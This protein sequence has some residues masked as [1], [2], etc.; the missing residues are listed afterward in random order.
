MPSAKP[1]GVHTRRLLRPLSVIFLLAVATRAASF[2]ELSGTDFFEV[3]LGDARR[4]D[5]WAREIIAGDLLGREVFYQAPLY[6]YFLALVYKLAGPSAWAVRIVQAVAGALACVLLALAARR[7]FSHRVGVLAGVMLA[8]YPPAV[9]FDGLLQKASLGLLFSTGLILLLASLEE[10]SRRGWW[11]AVGTA[12]GA[13][14][15]LRENALVLLPVVGLWL[16]VEFRRLGKVELSYR[17]ALFTLGLALLLVPVGLRNQVVGGRFLVT[18]SQAGSNFFIGNNLEANG[19]YR[20]LRPRGGDAR[21]ERTDAAEL[22]EADLGRQLTPG[23]VSDY[24]FAESADY[25]RAHPSHW[26]RLMFDKWLLVWNAE[27]IVDTDS[28]EAHG[29]E[30]RPLRALNSLWHFGVL[31]PFALTGMW[32]TRGRWRRLW[33]LYG[34]LAALASSVA[35]FYVVAR[36]RFPLTPILVLFAAAGVV[37]VFSLMKQRKLATLVPAA[38]VLVLAAIVT[39][40]PVTPAAEVIDSRATN[41]LN[42]GVTLAEGGDPGAA[43]TQ[44]ER[45][46]ALVPGFAPAQEALGRALAREGRPAQAIP[47]FERALEIEPGNAAAHSQI[48]YLQTQIGGLDRAVWHLR[49]AIDIDPDFA[50]AHNQLA[51]IA[52]SRGLLEQAES[53]YRRSLEIDPDLADAHFKLGRLLAPG[54]DASAAV[55]LSAAARL[56]P[57][58]ADA[59]F[60]LGVVLHR[61]ARHAEA[62]IAYQRVLELEPD[63]PGA[64]AGLARLVETE[65]HADNARSSVDGQ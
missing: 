44:L 60:S 4:Y 59:H 25:I 55:H 10:S 13:L 54:D 39:N 18:T 46:V 36:Y 2:F 5:E 57:D 33:L 50:L 26:L 29:D 12:M 31:A 30:S 27:E 8:V 20:P 40:R 35:V 48:A 3:L 21:V 56:L 52:A 24:W 28:I 22:A 11:L 7:F 61:L 64:V 6:P 41:Y 38:G 23:E 58:F 53:G 19:R 62:R 15:L 1:E 16:M 49:Q 17:A 9:F 34:M 47:H 51:N 14:V 37:E 63:H 65:S 32:L 42:L 43:V 45:A